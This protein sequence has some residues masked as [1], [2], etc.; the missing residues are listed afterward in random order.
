M[1]TGVTF[2]CLSIITLLVVAV[3][4][5]FQVFWERTYSATG[6]GIDSP[7]VTNGSYRK[8]SVEQEMLPLDTKEVQENGNGISEAEA[9][10]SL[11]ANLEEP[12]TDLNDTGNT[13]LTET[14]VD[15]E[16]VGT[17][18]ENRSFQ[19]YVRI[20]CVNTV[21]ACLL[22]AIFIFNL[23]YIALDVHFP[24]IIYHAVSELYGGSETTTTTVVEAKITTTEAITTAI[25][26]TVD[27]IT[28][29]MGTA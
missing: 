21:I 3:L 2:A 9:G 14:A 17:Q 6:T 8:G 22:F 28:S 4:A 10:E 11:T 25:E 5:G 13:Q 24:H 27:F 20:N 26:E 12:V 1:F 18:T 19:L 7:I 23:V 15:E 16:N 29:T